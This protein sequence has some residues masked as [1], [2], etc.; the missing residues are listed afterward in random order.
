[1]ST[2]KKIDHRAR[3]GKDDV[4][5]GDKDEFD[6]VANGAHDQEANDAG[7]Q[8]FHVL[9]VVRLLALLVKHDGVGHESFGLV[10][11]VELLVLLLLFLGHLAIK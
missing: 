3:S 4:V 9:S 2:S 6:E 11:D 1:M 10:R 5:D 8:D 7:L